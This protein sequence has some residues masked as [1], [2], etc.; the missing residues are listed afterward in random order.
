MDGADFGII[1]SIKYL[2][3][4]PQQ[5]KEIRMFNTNF[6][7]KPGKLTIT[8]DAS[9][10]SSGK[11][12]LGSFITHYADNWQFAINTFYPQAGH[13]VKLED[14]RSFFYQTFNSCAYQDKYEKIYIAPGAMIELPAFFRELEENKIPRNKIG[15]SPLAAILQDIDAGFEKGI[16]DFD[17]K[18]LDVRQDGTMKRGTTAHGCGA[19]RARRV[20]R[21]PE[22]KYAKDIPELKEFLC[23]VS[24]EVMERLGEG[25]SGLMEVAQGFQLSYLLHEFFPY[26]TSRNCTTMAAMDDAM[27]PIHYAGDV[28]INCRTLPIRINNF[29]YIAPDGHHLT[30]AEK[31]EYDK[32]SKKYEKYEGSSGPG[33]VD[34][35]EITWDEVTKWSG[36]KTPI[37]EMTSVTKL[38]RRVFSFSRINLTDAIK[39]NRANGKVYIS[40]N[41]MN[42]IDSEVS[43]INGKLSKISD[44]TQ[45]AKTWCEDYL[46]LEQQKMLKFIG[47]GAMLNDQILIS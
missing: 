40:V 42:Y 35:K 39:Y 30:W 38:P 20:L 28:I 21:R 24:E 41:F 4:R 18:K 17:G 33:Y 7:F 45:R 15:I 37:I 2:K 27:L 8:L 25:Q 14:G 44:L 22:A 26:T 13:W 47:T 19:C 6:V 5:Y 1:C 34:Q 36:S 9:A 29:K 11:G 16:L 23:N 32:E 46:T 3:A 12:K 10:G 43:K 31:C